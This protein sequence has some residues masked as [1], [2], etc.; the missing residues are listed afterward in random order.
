MQQ[1]KTENKVA[2]YFLSPKFKP[3]KLSKYFW[4]FSLTV[5]FIAVIMLCAI[6]FNLGMDFTGGNIISIKTGAAVS[7]SATYNNVESRVERVL[8]ENGLSVSQIQKAGTGAETEVQIQYQN[9]NGDMTAINEKVKADLEA[10]FLAEGYTVMP[11]QTKS[12]SASGEL[13]L[14]SLLALAIAILVILIYI[15]IR[16]ELVSGLAAIITLFHDVFVMCAFV[17]I[18]RIEVNAAFIAALITILGYSVNNTIVVFDRIREN[19]RLDSLS[20]LSNA[21]IADLSVRQT[22]TRTMGT[23]ITTIAAVLMLAIIGVSSIQQFI[24]PILLGLLVGTYAAIFISAPLWVKIVTNSRFDRRSPTYI[25]KQKKAKNNEI[26]NT[27]T[28][29]E[30]QAKPVEE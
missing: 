27:E 13:L 3:S 21:E 7:D 26:S 11:S 12:A 28:V 1:N 17:I 24:I 18:F 8:S 5:I 4:A 30:A 22:L 10:E 15:A 6:G 9:I 25:A 16:F 19:L 14:N 23:S 2:K 29:V 20:N